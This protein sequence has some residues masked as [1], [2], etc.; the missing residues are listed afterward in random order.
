MKAGLVAGAIIGAAIIASTGVYIYFT[1]YQTCVRWY[2]E[3]VPD[4]DP[5]Q[6]CLAMMRGR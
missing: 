4:T 2:R 1:P 5:T 3:M 6:Y